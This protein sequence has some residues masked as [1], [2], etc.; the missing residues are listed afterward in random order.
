MTY[1]PGFWS[2]N[3]LNS[4]VLMSI[5]GEFQCN[6]LQCVVWEMILANGGTVQGRNGGV[7][8]RSS[9]LLW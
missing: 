1:V 8:R 4:T 6:R 2:V 3:G 7:G 9:S 5:L